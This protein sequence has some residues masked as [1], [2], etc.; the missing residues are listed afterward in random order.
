MAVKNIFISAD[1]VIA[2]YKM[3]YYNGAIWLFV[4]NVW[5]CLDAHTKE[6]YKTAYLKAKIDQLYQEEYNNLSKDQKKA[7]KVPTP[8]NQI[9]TGTVIGQVIAFHEVHSIFKGIA[10]RNGIVKTNGEGFVKT[11]DIPFTT[12]QI[13][14][15]YVENVKPNKVF[16]KWLYQITGGDKTIMNKYLT[17]WSY[18]LSSETL[19]IFF[20]SWGNKG[21]GKSEVIIKLSEYIGR[22]NNKKIKSS[23]LFGIH[24]NNNSR[25]S[26]RKVNDKTMLYMD[27]FVEK[28]A[29]DAGNT[30]KL[31]MNENGYLEYENK[32]TNDTETLNTHSWF[33]SANHPPII[34]DIDE[35]LKDRMVIGIFKK[36][37]LNK[38]DLISFMKGEY[39]PFLIT[40]LVK[41][42]TNS[43]VFKHSRN[44][45]LK[46]EE[47][48][49]EW[50]ESDYA[51]TQEE[52]WVLD[53]KNALDNEG[54]DKIK[55]MYYDTTGNRTNDT[56]MGTALKNCHFIKSRDKG[57]R[58][59]KYIGE[60]KNK[61]SKIIGEYNF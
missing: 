33:A 41:A 48:Q 8:R 12:C 42:Y 45:G 27:E 38:K 57:V 54:I 3:K 32:G 24:S 17:I 29:H 36:P 14:R 23:Q 9:D 21:I 50:L 15:D 55:R 34:R 5:E 53:N 30:L 37:D 60:E 47:F 26:L 43:S 49:E 2:R 10:F 13:N 18:A 7:Y 6:G 40:K 4:D 56:R 19:G 44:V 58:V 59:Y 20:Y 51:K 11:K 22:V 52:L 1:D 28:C 35:E 46:I 39:I 31:F 25:F 61:S 16:L